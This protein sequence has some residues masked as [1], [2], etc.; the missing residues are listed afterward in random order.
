MRKII[1]FILVSLA[2]VGGTG[3]SPDEGLKVVPYQVRWFCGVTDPKFGCTPEYF[4][5]TDIIPV[6]KDRVNLIWY[7][8]VIANV[9]NH[10]DYLT[11]VTN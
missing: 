1:L 10:P 4:W 9:Y 8:E 7:G 3:Q 6:G 2:T 5:V 11:I